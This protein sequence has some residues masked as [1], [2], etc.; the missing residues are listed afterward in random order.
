MNWET[1]L[2]VSF[3]AIGVIQY[4]KGFLTKAPTIVWALASPVL[5]I[6]FSAA[7]AIMPSW[8]SQGILALALSQLGYETIIQTIKNKFGAKPQT[9]A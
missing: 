5:C 4:L 9:G 3:S 8:V 1:V 7:W 2:F 6:A